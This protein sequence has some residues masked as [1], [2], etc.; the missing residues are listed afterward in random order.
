[1]VRDLLHNYLQPRITTYEK[2]AQL[3][4]A[5]EYDVDISG[6]NCPAYSLGMCSGLGLDYDS[7]Y[8]CFGKD[9]KISKVGH[10]QH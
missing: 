9:K 3:L 4:G 6:G 1:M 8:V 2:V 7:L 10:I 5:K